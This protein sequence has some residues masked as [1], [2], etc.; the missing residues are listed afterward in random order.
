MVVPSRFIK[1]P[2]NYV[3]GKY[4]LLAQMFPLFPA[5]V[6]TFVDLFAGGGDV[7]INV[8]AEKV[9][10]NDI[11]H[12]VIDL[13]RTF[14]DYTVAELIARIEHTID[15][16]GLSPTNEI[17]YK[18]FREY[19]NRNKN[20][21][22]LFILV[23]HSF[24][25]QFRFNSALEYNNPFGRNRSWFNPTLKNN[26]IS[27]VQRLREI[28]F[29]TD[30]FKT[31]DFTEL[32]EGDFVYADPPYLITTGSYNDGKRGFEGWSEQ[33]E[34]AL[35]N[36]LDELDRRNIRFALSNVIEHKGRQ[37]AIL[38]EWRNRYTT[39]YL[40]KTYSNSSYHA[41]KIEKET[42]EVLVTNY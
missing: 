8:S 37:N 27:F 3:G 21:L 13:F 24:N 22:D 7:F 32:H 28:E 41:K 20:P 19:Y 4:K 31:F 17:A 40:N 6:N 39:H 23:C 12:F 38:E 16:W 10:A 5:H 15:L 18:E 2:L 34:I 36:T 11:N 26:L 35:Y 9:I 29:R 33:E 30:N 14:K 1:S 42:R 25:Y